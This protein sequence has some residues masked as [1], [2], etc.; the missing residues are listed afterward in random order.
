MM[1]D[2]DQQPDTLNALKSLIYA[3]YD[4]DEFLD[5]NDNTSELFASKYL[6]ELINRLSIA[7]GFEELGLVLN[8]QLDSVAMSAAKASTLAYILTEL[9][10]NTIKHSGLDKGQTNASV[11]ME[12]QEDGVVAFDYSDNGIN[13]LNIYEL[14]NSRG[15]G[16]SLICQFTKALGSEMTVKRINGFTHFSFSFMP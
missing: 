1:G 14:K 10:T 15:K 4:V 8:C 5:H 12:L 16:W 2:A 7:H 11:K 13:E 6:E 3:A 9:L